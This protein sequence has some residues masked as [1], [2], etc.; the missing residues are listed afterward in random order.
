MESLLPGVKDSY[1]KA[2]ICLELS[3]CYAGKKI[4]DQALEFHSRGSSILEEFFG[5][6]SSMF[7]DSL[8][9]KVTLSFDMDFEDSEIDKCLEDHFAISSQIRI[10]PKREEVKSSLILIGKS[11]EKSEFCVESLLM[12]I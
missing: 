1:Y 5:K 10:K 2:K 12:K 3:K 9:T 4:K 8:Y 11:N 7:L 6:T